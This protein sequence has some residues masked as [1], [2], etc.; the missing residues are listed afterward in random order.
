MEWSDFLSFLLSILFRPS[1]WHCLDA[2]L[3]F[4]EATPEEEEE[5]EDLGPP[6]EEEEG[7]EEREKEEE[8]EVPPK[9]KQFLTLRHLKCNIFRVIWF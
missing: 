5:E 7:K 9:G 4:S 8:N 2:F 1:W 6:G 3:L